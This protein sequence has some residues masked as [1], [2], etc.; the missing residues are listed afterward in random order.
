METKIKLKKIGNSQ[1]IFI[2][3]LFCEHINIQIGDEIIIKDDNGK[4]GKFI[5]FWKVGDN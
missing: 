1:A 2:P 3:K 5:S 4:R